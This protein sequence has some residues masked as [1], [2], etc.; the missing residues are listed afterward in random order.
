MLSLLFMDDL[1]TIIRWKL[2]TF[3]GKCRYI[4]PTW[5]IPPTPHMTHNLPPH[6][7][8]PPA[9]VVRWRAEILRKWELTKA[10]SSCYKCRPAEGF[11]HHL[12]HEMG[13]K[14]AGY[15]LLNLLGCLLTGFLFH[16]GLWNNPH[17]TEPENYRG[18]LPPITQAWIN[19]D[20]M[21]ISLF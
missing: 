20:A 14:T 7:T 16:H 4:L 3:K 8:P 21:I 6:P 5:S 11:F 18:I 2:A 12:S 13:K 15:F 1:P 19:G 17:I 9:P 10:K